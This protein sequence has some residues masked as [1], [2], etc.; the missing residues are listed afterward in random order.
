L[1]PTFVHLDPALAAAFTGIRE[2]VKNTEN[3]DK[4]A[5]SLLSTYKE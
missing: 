4:N 2:R 3:I 5:I 1:A